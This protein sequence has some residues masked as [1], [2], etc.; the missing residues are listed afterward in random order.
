MQI[1]KTGAAEIIPEDDLREKIRQSLVNNKPIIV[2]HGLDPTAPDIHLGHT[3]PLQKM[4][5]FQDLGH[6]PLL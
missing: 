5:Q 2:K 1:L 3:V 6:R 4:R